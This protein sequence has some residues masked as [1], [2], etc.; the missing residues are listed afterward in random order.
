MATT[1]ITSCQFLRGGVALCDDF[2]FVALHDFL[3]L[4]TTE[5]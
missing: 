3:V 1:F 5:V 2:I 4:G